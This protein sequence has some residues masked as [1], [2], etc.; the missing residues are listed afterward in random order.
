MAN[1]APLRV[2]TNAGLV[3]LRIG[4]PVGERVAPEVIIQHHRGGGIGDIVTTY[5]RSNGEPDGYLIAM[6]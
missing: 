1:G 4:T 3:N 6:P 2:R 5:P